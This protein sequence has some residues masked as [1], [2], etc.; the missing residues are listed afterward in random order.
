MFKGIFVINQVVI[1]YLIMRRVLLKII[2]LV[3]IM[4]IIS[5]YDFFLIFE[6][7]TLIIV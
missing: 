4:N 5:N 2:K 6:H 1:K 7:T 3:S